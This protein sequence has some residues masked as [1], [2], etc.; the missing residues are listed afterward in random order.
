MLLN[1]NNIKS[2]IR[3]MGI[4]LVGEGIMMMLCALPAWHFHDGTIRQVV[5]SGLFTVLMGIMIIL[6]VPKP[7]RQ[8]E[9]RI[10]YLLVSLMWLVMMCFATLPFLTTGATS[11]FTRA[12]FEAISGMTTTGATIFSE[13]EALPA[14]IIMWRSM[15]HWIGGYGIVL[16]VLAVVPSLGINKYSLYTAETSGADNTGKVTTSMAHTVQQTLAAYVIITI[17]YIVVLC[18]MGMGPWDAINLTFAC[19]STGGFSPYG[20]SIAHFPAAQQYMLAAIMLTGGLNFMLLYHVITLQW[21]KIHGKM[22]QLR[23]YLGIMMAATCFVVLAL[24]WASGYDWNDALRLGIVQTASAASTTGVVVSDV[25]L[26]WTPILFVFLVLTLCG[27]MAGSTSGGLKTMRVLILVRNV[28][29]ILRN[30]LHPN[31]V[32]PVRLNG[33]PVSASMIDNVMVIFLVYLVTVMVST[34]LLLLCGVG[35]IESIGATVACLTSYGPGLG[36]CGGFG[37]Y[38]FMPSP[39]LWVLIFV[40]LMGRLE[41]L[42][43]LIILMPD[44]WRK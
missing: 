21:D 28:R 39:A 37:N 6:S 17:A 7:K 10:S 32:N 1:R 5:L 15:L 27:G 29:T 36:L 9:Q 16:L 2:L 8:P 4:P 14:S 34:A 25:G 35:G 11:H 43:L 31:A 3:P 13:V 30:R 44:F 19:I 20:N 41:C 23:A 42:T 12:C 22:D 38:A 18:L 40:M 26:W 33:Q 24:H